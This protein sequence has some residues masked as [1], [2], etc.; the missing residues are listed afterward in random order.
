MKNSYKIIDERF[1]ASQNAFRSYT[2]GFVLSLLCTVAPYYMVTRQV[3]AEYSLVIAA[4]FFGVVQL[5][6]Q[7]IFFLHLHPKSRP[8]WNV[9]VFVYTLVIVS[10]LVVGSLWI[11]HN[12]NMNMMGATP[13]NSNEGYIPSRDLQQ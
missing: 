5:I 3:F 6:V 9:I 10:F 12:L 4:V 2:T 11:M 8:H 13:F 7:V 1:E